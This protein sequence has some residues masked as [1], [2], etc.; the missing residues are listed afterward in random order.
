MKR[1]KSAR[2]FQCFASM[3]DPIANLFHIP[4]CDILSGSARNRDRLQIGR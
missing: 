3:H 1:F 2:Q 4:R